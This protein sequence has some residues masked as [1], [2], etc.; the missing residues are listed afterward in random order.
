MR[1]TKYIVALGCAA[2]L[3][4]C[5]ATVSSDDEDEISS[6]SSS[7]GKKKSSSST[8]KKSSSSE[9]SDKKSSATEKGIAVQ[10]TPTTKYPAVLKKMV[11][12]AA[13]LKNLMKI[14]LVNP[15]SL[16]MEPQQKLSHAE[17]EPNSAPTLS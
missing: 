8:S 14:A 4:A 1:L 17:R 11:N 5:S 9:S 13:L 10:A 2:L 12:Q 6:V 7:S 3:G 15:A 16:G